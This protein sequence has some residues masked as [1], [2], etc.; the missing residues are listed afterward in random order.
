MIKSKIV[1]TVLTF[2][3]KYFYIAL[4]ICIWLYVCKY[5]I[6]LEQCLKKI[7]EELSDFFSHSFLV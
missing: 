7:K 6:A 2:M 3:V 4:N 1:K 5:E